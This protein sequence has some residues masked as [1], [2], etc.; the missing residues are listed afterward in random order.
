[1]THVCAFAAKSQTSTNITSTTHNLKESSLSHS[2]HVMR[3]LIFSSLL[4]AS[5]S[6]FQASVQRSSHRRHIV[7]ARAKETTSKEDAAVDFEDCLPWTDNEREILKES[8]KRHTVVISDTHSF[9][10]W[11]AL[12]KSTPRLADYPLVTLVKRYQEES[13][14]QTFVLWRALVKSMP[15][16]ADYPLVT[17][18]KRYQEE[19]EDPTPLYCDLLPYL[20]SYKFTESGDAL[21][22]VLGTGKEHTTDRLHSN[23][24]QT[25]ALGYVGTT[26]TA[27]VQF[28]ELGEPS[29]TDT[30]ED[31]SSL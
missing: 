29:K 12:V 31:V 3:L 13:E 24:M 5:L 2:H 21:T 16:L 9:I 1:M 14:D 19:S 10:L 28:Y 15:R 23:A 26:S 11:R 7:V 8:V 20:D 25:L 27:N 4:L 17:L 22:G 18:F 30:G 6:A